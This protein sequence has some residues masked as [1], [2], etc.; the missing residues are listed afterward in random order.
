MLHQ[1]EGVFDDFEPV[2]AGE[3]DVVALATAVNPFEGCPYLDYDRS[4]QEGSNHPETAISDGEFRPP[5]RLTVETIEP[6]E[7]CQYLLPKAKYFG[8]IFFC[9][10][11]IN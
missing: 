11:N 8:G 4:G 2:D 5:I 7:V 1:R 10:I 3:T 6:L 9:V